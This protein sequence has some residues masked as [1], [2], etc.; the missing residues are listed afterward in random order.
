MHLQLLQPLLHH[1]LQPRRSP[2]LRALLGQRRLSFRLAEA[3]YLAAKGRYLLFY[4][5]VLLDVLERVD[6]ETVLEV[7]FAL[8]VEQGPR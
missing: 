7:Y 4:R 5:L 6:V 1:F 3:R 2:G 8:E